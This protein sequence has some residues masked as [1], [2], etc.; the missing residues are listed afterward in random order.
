MYLIPRDVLPHLFPSLQA[1]AILLAGAGQTNFQDVFCFPVCNFK[2]FS[3]SLELG[4]ERQYLSSRLFTVHLMNVSAL[5]LQTKDFF[6]KEVRTLVPSTTRRRTHSC[7]LMSLKPQQQ[8]FYSHIK[9][10]IQVRNHLCSWLQK[11]I[12]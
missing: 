7:R 5:K 4:H 9:N 11:M 12:L 2:N 6:H 3:Y 1:E 8:R 10:I